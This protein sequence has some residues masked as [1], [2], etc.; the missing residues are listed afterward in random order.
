MRRILL[1]TLL[2]NY[3]TTSATTRHVPADYPTIQSALYAANSDDIVLVAPGTYYENLVWPLND[4]SRILLQGDSKYTTFINGNGQGSVIQFINPNHPSYIGEQTVVSDFTIENGAADAGGGI[5]MDNSSP[6]LQNL[7]IRNCTAESEGGGIYI[8]DGH[9][10][11]DNLE[12]YNNDAGWMGGGVNFRGDHSWFGRGLT[13]SNSL[14]Y[15][16]HCWGPAGIACWNDS[17]RISHCTFA[18][19]YNN[20]PPLWLN[21]DATLELENSIFWFN[22]PYQLAIV[23]E[24]FVSNCNLHGGQEYVYEYSPGVIHWDGL[25]LAEDPLFCDHDNDDYRLQDESPCFYTLWPYPFDYMGYT[26]LNCHGQHVESV[27][28]ETPEQ[29]DLMRAYPNPFNPYTTIELNSTRPGETTISIYNVRG[30]VVDVIHDGFLQ[31]GIHTL[32]WQP[33]NLASGIY[34]VNLRIENQTKAIKITYIE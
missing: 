10:T 17:V 13:L 24:A 30:Q 16:N 11:L 22:T 27:S 6:T 7:R 3:T 12:I 23:G 19:N 21:D 1:L 5:Y 2:F 31:A 33:D 25:I 29:F 34:F 4:W 20:A 26:D 32:T 14:I 15:R 28:S 18:D 9:P 8:H